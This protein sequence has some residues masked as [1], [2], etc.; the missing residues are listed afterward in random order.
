MAK[1]I[2]YA[3]VSTKSQTTDRQIMDLIA[4]GIRKDDVYV[5][6]GVSG[7]RSAARI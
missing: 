7:G 4:A 3:R 6:H 1:L 2:G 5:D